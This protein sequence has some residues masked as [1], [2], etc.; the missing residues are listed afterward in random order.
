MTHNIIS[1][2]SGFYG[3]Q[4]IS[5]GEVVDA[6]LIRWDGHRGTS[7]PYDSM[8]SNFEF[9]QDAKNTVYYTDKDGVNARIWC[10]GDRLNTHCHRL[11]QIKAR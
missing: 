7:Y 9:Y 8:C 5:S 2:A 6:A 3:L 11:Q 4:V 1:F 10:P